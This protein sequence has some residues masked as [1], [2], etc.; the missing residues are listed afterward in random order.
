MTLCGTSRPCNP[1]STS[2]TQACPRETPD[3]YPA[4]VSGAPR[5]A[6][7]A[8]EWTR[9]KILAAMNG[10]RPLTVTLKDKIRVF[11]VYGT[12]LATEKGNVLF[13][14]DIYRHDERLQKALEA[15]RVRSAANLGREPADRS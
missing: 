10:T 8:P 14:D 4:G 7:D 5:N 3:R 11:I 12:A 15:R 9:E 1:P 13:F 6:K 2:G